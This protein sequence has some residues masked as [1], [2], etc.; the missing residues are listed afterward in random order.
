MR[1][2]HLLGL[3]VD[4]AAHPLKSPLRSLLVAPLFV[5]LACGDPQETSV[6]DTEATASS[7]GSD[8]TAGPDATETTT[9]DGMT[10][11]V[12]ETT[13]TTTA[14]TD[15]DA[16]DS[17][18]TDSDPTD[19]TTDTGVFPW[20][21]ACEDEP[22]P[23]C[24][25]EIDKCK[26]DS[27]R[28]GVHFSCD[29]APAHTNPAQLDMDKDSFGDITDTCPTVQS[30]VN[31]ADGDRDG[32]G[33]DCD[34]CKLR[35]STAYNKD[36]VGVPA[37][38][39]VRNIPTQT[40]ADRDGV[41]DVCDNCVR[42]ANC[43]GYGD[44]DGLTPFVVG[45]PIDVEAADCQADA[46]NDKIGDACVGV[47][48]EGA[49]GPVGFGNDDD[50]DQ[51]GLANLIDRCPRLPVH[52][53]TC[54]SD[55]DCPSGSSC[56]PAGLCNHA[57]HD[58][59]GAGDACDTCP[60][61]A[62]P[63]Q[64]VE[65]GMQVDDADEDFVGAACEQDAGCESRVNPR[66]FGFYDISVNGFCCVTSY[67]GE[68]LRDA[69]G[70]LVDIDDLGPRPPGVVELPAGCEEAL[71]A[72]SDGK[73]HVIQACHVDDISELWRYLCLLPPWDQDFDAIPDV[74]DKCPFVYDPSNANYVDENNKEW[75]DIG[76]ACNGDHS[77]D[78]WGLENDC[79]APPQP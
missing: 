44:E 76:A 43:Q 1:I 47:I 40:D 54:A 35:P 7:S 42:V 33:N 77:P 59:D 4:Y 20:P 58:D 65:G 60:G 50:F 9:D 62:N 16:T 57:D 13:D 19:A 24:A 10:D 46:E 79:A 78:V 29:N 41:G 26:L 27:D 66:P 28:D 39:L 38:M 11:T 73:A 21:G 6:T 61:V 2:D 48:A 22:W 70:Y 34:L 36:A 64:L 17:E 8:T 51:D 53:R 32:V 37:Y 63:M 18:S 30:L 71:A 25:E 49:A 69:D 15:S 23:G 5:A 72:S 55:D 74:C 14:S 45:M 67:N 12:A 52:K 31:T 56:A 68:E 75:P 3:P